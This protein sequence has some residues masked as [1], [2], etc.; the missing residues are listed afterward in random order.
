[1]RVLLRKQRTPYKRYRCISNESNFTEDELQELTFYLCHM[2]ACCA[3]AVSYPMPA[4]N[5]H[6]A[7]YRGR[8]WIQAITEEETDRDFRKKWKNF[9]LNIENPMFFI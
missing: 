3:R 4:Y 5:A 1:M 9:N 8:V 6:L 7:A 2:N